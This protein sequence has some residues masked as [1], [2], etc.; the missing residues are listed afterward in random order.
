MCFIFH[1]LQFSFCFHVFLFFIVFSCFNLFF[2]LVIVFL[3]FLDSFIEQN[4]LLN[5]AGTN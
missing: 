2:M 5:N 4:Y 3:R 1:C